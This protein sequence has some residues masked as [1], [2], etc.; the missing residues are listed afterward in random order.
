MQRLAVFCVLIAA[1][2]CAEPRGW[3]GNLAGDYQLVATCA[4][5][6]LG[7]QYGAIGTIRDDQRIAILASPA[8]E[9]AVVYEARLQE[10]APQ[11]IFAE[12]REGG[13]SPAALAAWRAIQACAP[14]GPDRV[15]EPGQ[16]GQWDWITG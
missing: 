9:G 5:D 12:V 6:L 15:H 1:A 8:R 10:T 4:A 14:G 13:D 7:P 16:P 11:R 2:G 3:R